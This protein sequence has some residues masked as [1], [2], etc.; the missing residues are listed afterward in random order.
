MAR[1]NDPNSAT[2]QFFI[3]VKDNA[4]LDFGINGAGYAV[5][6]QVIEGMD[7]V[8]KIVAVPTT[9]RG[10]HQN[11][12]STPVVIQRVREAPAA[13]PRPASPKPASSPQP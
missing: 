2:S 11:I 4:S 10:E 6:G 12:P 7:V 1:T 8:D 3:N 5:F 13:R 9:M